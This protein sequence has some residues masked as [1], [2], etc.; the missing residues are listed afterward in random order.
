MWDPE[1]VA[2]YLDVKV[3]D[4][5]VT[6]K[7]DVDYQFQSDRAFDHATSLY[8]VTGVTN[9]IKVTQAL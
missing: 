1:L 6:L 2:G 9:E 8:G 5:W 4:G 3:K 7:G